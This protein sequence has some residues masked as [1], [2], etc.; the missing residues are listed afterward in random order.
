MASTARLLL[1]IA[2][3]LPAPL[4]FAQQQPPDPRSQ[5][6]QD[7]RLKCREAAR[8]ICDVGNAPDREAFR[9]CVTENK[10]KLPPECAAPGQ[11]R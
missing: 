4:T 7:V 11:K 8:T 3:V 6:S 1:I 9:R 5:T 2:V 10:D